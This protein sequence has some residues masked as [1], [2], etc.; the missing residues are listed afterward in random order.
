[1]PESDLILRFQLHGDLDALVAF[2]ASLGYGEGALRSKLELLRPIL[3][4][5]S[6]G[7]QPRYD[8]LDRTRFLEHRNEAQFVLRMMAGSRSAPVRSAATHLIKALGL[9]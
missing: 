8:A 4:D 5:A 9:E 6:V 2:G 7:K 3:E 1:M